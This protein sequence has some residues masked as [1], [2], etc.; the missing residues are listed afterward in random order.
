MP[1]TKPTAEELEAQTRQALAELDKPETPEAPKADPKPEEQQETPEA[2]KA[3]PEPEEQQE[4]QSDIDYRKKFAESTREAQVLHAKNKKLN[5][6]IELA[7]TVPDITEK[8]LVAEYSDWENMTELEKKMAKSSLMNE[9]RFQALQTAT[10]EFKDIDAWSAKVDQYISDANTLVV[11]PELEGKTEEFKTFA[12]KASRRGV[13]FPDLVSAFLFQ[14]EKGKPIKKGKMF[15]TGTSGP[16]ATPKPPSDK[17]TLADA[18]VLM[19]QD[20]NKYKSLL[21]A[22]KIDLTSI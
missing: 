5:E 1:H 8:E 15:E 20:Y 3:D 21:K 17:I 2:P 14:T 13:D 19:K 4:T 9:R 10:K 22:G 7:S 11:N 18:Q 12:I 6:A 16:N